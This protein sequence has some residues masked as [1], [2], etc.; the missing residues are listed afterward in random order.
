MRR[1]AIAIALALSTFCFGVG[2]K[3]DS[4]E[5][6]SP[7]IQANPIKTDFSNNVYFKQDIAD[8]FSTWRSDNVYFR[9]CNI[10]DS[11]FNII[12]HTPNLNGQYFFDGKSYAQQIYFPTNSAPNIPS[13][14]LT[15]NDR[16]YY[17]PE[18]WYVFPLENLCA[19]RIRNGIEFFRI[20]TGESVSSFAFKSSVSY[21]YII[22]KGKFAQ[23]FDNTTMH[24]VNID[25]GEVL[26][27]SK[28]GPNWDAGNGVFVTPSYIF[29][30][31]TNK[32]YD[33]SDFGLEMRTEFRIKKDY[34]EFYV[35]MDTS[36]YPSKILDNPRI[37][38]IGYDGVQ[39]DLV[40]MSFMP[41]DSVYSILNSTGEIAIVSISMQNGFNIKA[42]AVWKTY[43]G[44]M[45]WQKTF[46]Q[47]SEVY[48]VTL[49]TEDKPKAIFIQ[50]DTI[51]KIDVLTGT[52]E[53][54]ANFKEHFAVT[55]LA[56][57]N[58]F[59]WFA[60]YDENFSE[61]SP[62][63]FKM[64][65]AGS[66]TPIKIPI[67]LANPQLG[68]C[69]GKIYIV[70]RN[71]ID[72]MS[73]LHVETLT[74]DPL[75]GNATKGL[76][77]LAEGVDSRAV[78]LEGKFLFV[79][80]AI[81]QTVY[82]LSTG[83]M[84]VLDDAR[85]TAC[86]NMSSKVAGDK[87]YVLTVFSD[88]KNILTVFDNN[89]VQLSK[90]R[91]LGDATEILDANDKYMALGKT[92]YLGMVVSDCNGNWQKSSSTFALLENDNVVYRRA[93]DGKYCRMN[94]ETRKTELLGERVPPSSPI[95]N[96]YGGTFF[97]GSNTF[98]RDLNWLQYRMDITQIFPTA[99]KTY[100]RQ[101]NYFGTV[102][103]LKPAPCYTLKRENAS[104]FTITNSR[105]DGL[106][107]DLSGYAVAFVDEGGVIEKPIKLEYPKY[108]ENLKP[109]QS[110]TVK[111]DL[112]NLNDN[113]SVYLAVFS[114]GFYDKK[115]TNPE[116][117][118]YAYVGTHLSDEKPLLVYIGGWVVSK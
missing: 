79:F 55:E 19:T 22:D 34:I 48:D 5:Q 80:G 67:K 87:V 46:S 84:V 69:N 64:D 14:L 96:F 62:V 10:I 6:L 77:F 21:F 2:A 54:K 41:K 27:E 76:S 112:G 56:F 36:R 86:T 72:E 117:L 7:L 47:W 53:K 30:Y 40:S 35:D 17:V 39:K 4:Q 73:A 50:G 61:T 74:I 42:L 88:K 100:A 63:V 109:G 26:I 68:F 57:E 58:N 91:G 75:T 59:F 3:T 118:K 28:I 95:T 113:T 116:P 83:K 78:K 111:F 37:L 106:A 8:T 104:T 49:I 20:D 9:N 51:L 98:D 110:V 52:I 114:N 71:R 115:N 65:A 44:Q 89:L 23:I 101:L 81:R 18:G 25:S 13:S 31:Q 29:N 66:K 93:T 92:N 102:V 16:Q 107:D 70:S 15:I 11:N 60:Q 1:L 85:S 12:R 82:D 45:L 32:S 108:F 97:N 99:N 90:N 33:I 43:T 105:K 38:R 103:E 94:I 24:F